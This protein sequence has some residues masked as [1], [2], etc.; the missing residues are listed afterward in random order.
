MTGANYLSS[1]LSGT[2]ATISSTPSLFNLGLRVSANQLFCFDMVAS[3]FTGAAN[4]M[5]FS[6]AG[7]TGASVSLLFEQ[8]TPGAYLSAVVG[9][10]GSATPAFFAGNLVGSLRVTGRIVNG[11]TAGTLTLFWQSATPGQSNTFTGVGK[12]MGYVSN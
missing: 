7:P 12:A 11:P 1:S 5:K 8:F 6:F 10:F 2:S 3:Q 4:G 9:G